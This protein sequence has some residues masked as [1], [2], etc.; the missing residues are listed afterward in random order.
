[1][2]TDEP[3]II[4]V[5]SSVLTLCNIS[6]GEG[7]ASA[8]FFSSCF[9]SLCT[10]LSCGLRRCY[11]WWN[12]YDLC[13][14]VL[15]WIGRKMMFTKK[16]SDEQASSTAIA[17]WFGKLGP[18][19]KHP[20]SCSELGTRNRNR[21][22]TAAYLFFSSPT[23]LNSWTLCSQIPEVSGFKFWILFLIY[24]DSFWFLQIDYQWAYRP[25]SQ[26][27]PAVIT[28]ATLKHF[29]PPLR[30]PHSKQQWTGSIIVASLDPLRP[31]SLISITVGNF[32]NDGKFDR[33]RKTTTSGKVWGIPTNLAACNLCLRS[34][35]F[36][37][38]YNTIWLQWIK[39]ALLAK[40]RII[41]NNAKSF[42]KGK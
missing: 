8:I 32:K 40:D 35:S 33:T 4:W 27:P 29:Q 3:C 9:R 2:W 5:C 41:S 13:Q 25:P 23:F 20:S 10:K 11:C 28:V 30:L 7:C 17:R 31:S 14:V 36:F 42:L 19:S 34:L 24:F 26:R 15:W 39:V 21:T 12:M 38:V 16:M 1:M 18:S 37:D 22:R 6:A